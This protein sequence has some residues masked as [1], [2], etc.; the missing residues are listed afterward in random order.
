MQGQEGGGAG[1][2]CMRDCG[3]LGARC[4]LF[5]ASGC[6]TLGL[7]NQQSRVSS[8]SKRATSR[9]S[10]TTMRYQ[11]ALLAVAAAACAAQPLAREMLVEVES[12]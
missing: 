12:V 9:G 11:F 7:C 5:R 1:S 2:A 10:C 4:M 6:E 8:S 3:W